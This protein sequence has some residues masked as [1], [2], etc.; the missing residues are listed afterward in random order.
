[1]FGQRWKIGRSNVQ[2]QWEMFEQQERWLSGGVCSTRGRKGSTRGGHLKTFDISGAYWCVA[3]EGVGG[4]FK[5][6]R[7]K[8]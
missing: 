2:V 1:M 3:V 4:T 7:R 8:V 5:W 6:R